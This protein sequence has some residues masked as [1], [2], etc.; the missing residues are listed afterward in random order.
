MDENMREEERGGAGG[1][2]AVG[3]ILR[4]STNLTVDPAIEV[5][6]EAISQND[7]AGPTVSW[8]DEV[9]FPTEYSLGRI[10]SEDGKFVTFVASTVNEDIIFEKIKARYLVRSFPWIVPVQIF[11]VQSYAD[12]EVP[13]AYPSVLSGLSRERCAIYCGCWT[14][15]HW[16]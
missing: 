6:D 3:L 7:S 9:D 12:T 10:I 16:Q 13:W 11:M 2:R 5:A 4:D 1:S 15:S 14:G 8:Y